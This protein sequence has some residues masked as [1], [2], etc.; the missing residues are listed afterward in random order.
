M[1]SHTQHSAQT[2]AHSADIIQSHAISAKD[3]SEQT[4]PLLSHLSSELISNAFEAGQ[5]CFVLGGPIGREVVFDLFYSLL[6]TQLEAF[7]LL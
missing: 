3:Q 7:L 4:L 2:I 6:G 5:Q 1:C